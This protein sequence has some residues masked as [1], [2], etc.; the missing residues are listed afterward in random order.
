MAGLAKTVDSDRLRILKVKDKEE[1]IRDFN[2]KVPSKE[3]L[4]GC[5]KAAKEAMKK[6]A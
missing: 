5:S 2:S 1:F 4:D 6:K 3:F